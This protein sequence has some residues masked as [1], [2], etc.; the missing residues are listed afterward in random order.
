MS[1]A[2]K[3]FALVVEDSQFDAKVVEVLLAQM[4]DYDI[5]IDRA[6]SLNEASEK[7]IH[8]E[9]DVILLDLGLPDS[10]G[11]ITVRC[12]DAIITGSVPIIAVTGDEDEYTQSEFYISGFEHY[13]LK[14][15]LNAKR[16]HEAV[17]NVLESAPSGSNDDEEHP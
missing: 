15:E 6:I 14:S 4:A 7:A 9:Y 8:N 5:A 2:K 17:K 10:H 13:I 1:D 16:L 3:I 12:M 11:S